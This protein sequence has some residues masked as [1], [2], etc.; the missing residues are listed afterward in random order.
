MAENTVSASTD[1][2]GTAALFPLRFNSNIAILFR[3]VTANF[4]F[5]TST[6]ASVTTALKSDASLTATQQVPSSR[7]FT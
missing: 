3:M 6:E 5:S 1:D 2:G 4:Y 7:C